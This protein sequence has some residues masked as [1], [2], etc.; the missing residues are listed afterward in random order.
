MSGRGIVQGEC[1]TLAK[2][3]IVVCVA[4][5]IAVFGALDAMTCGPVA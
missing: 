4:Y 2:L 1:P 3:A 5:G